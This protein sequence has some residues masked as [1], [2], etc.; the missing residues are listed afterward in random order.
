L[1]AMKG[2]GNYMLES[3]Q[4]N[5]A[6]GTHNSYVHGYK[7]GYTAGL[8]VIMLWIPFFVWQGFHGN[9]MFELKVGGAQGMVKGLLLDTK[10]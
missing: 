10:Q 9:L 8:K 1:F 2:S 5:C 3:L 7:K 4:A 6:L